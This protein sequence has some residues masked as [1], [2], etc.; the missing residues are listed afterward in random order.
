M[1]E[2]GSQSNSNFNALPKEPTGIQG[3]DE[4]TEGGLPKVDRSW[5]ADLPA[6][7]KRYLQ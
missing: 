1:T 7:E 2:S 5:F 6:P 3:L 4:I